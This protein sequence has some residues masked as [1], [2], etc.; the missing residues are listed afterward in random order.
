MSRIAHQSH[1]VEEHTT[2]ELGRDDDRIESQCE[3]EPRAEVLEYGQVR[4]VGSV[5]CSSRL[6]KHPATPGS[7]KTATTAGS[8]RRGKF[9]KVLF[10]QKAVLSRKPL[11][12][13]RH[14]LDDGVP[15]DKML[16]WESK[17]ARSLVRPK[18]DDG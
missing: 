4:H 16:F 11:S 3:I 7:G 15:R 17:I 2:D 14:F 13:S 1:A 8:T 10:R 18:V 6:G 9:E 12:G 5:A